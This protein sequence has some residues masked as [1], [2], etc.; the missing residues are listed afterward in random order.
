MHFTLN[1]IKTFDWTWKGWNLNSRV[2]LS[3]IF[4][5]FSKSIFASKAL[6]RRSKYIA[7]HV[8]FAQ[9]HA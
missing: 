2:I 9:Q 4:K 6:I 1:L 3:K 8:Q 7:K 5:G